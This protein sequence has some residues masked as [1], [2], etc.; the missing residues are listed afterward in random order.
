[1]EFSHRNLMRDEYTTLSNS[2]LTSENIEEMNK[3]DENQISSKDALEIINDI[4]NKYPLSTLDSLE[5]IEI[6]ERLE[7]SDASEKFTISK[8]LG[9]NE[10]YGG[11][12]NV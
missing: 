9:K 1:M 3:I 2:N 4:E 6:K 8:L 11:T 7:N 10:I 5:F 12:R